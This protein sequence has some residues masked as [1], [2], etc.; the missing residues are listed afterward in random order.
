MHTSSG[1]SV[2]VVS[3]PY[4]IEI[5]EILMLMYCFS[6]IHNMPL[7]THFKGCA[8]MINGKAALI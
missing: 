6:S 2:C 5:L 8:Q 3:N 1:N 7:Q 4:V